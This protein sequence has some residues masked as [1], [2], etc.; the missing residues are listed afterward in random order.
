LNTFFFHLGRGTD[1]GLA[2][3]QRCF[4]LL[5][6]KRQGN[7]MNL[8]IE[9]NVNLTC[10]ESAAA[11]RLSAGSS[12]RQSTFGFV[13]L[14]MLVVLLLV[15]RQ[16]QFLQ[17]LPI[18]VRTSMAV[19]DESV[20]V[21]AATAIV[22]GCMWCCGSTKKHIVSMEGGNTRIGAPTIRLVPRADGF[23]MVPLYFCSNSTHNEADA[24]LTWHLLP[25][26]DPRSGFF[27]NAQIKYARLCGQCGHAD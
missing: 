13:L 4:F 27:S 17:G 21:V 7:H 3:P 2:V 9:L 5:C 11:C 22:V 8:M 6:L 12:C 26:S 1:I 16:R 19:L 20:V 25:F 14:V 24:L 15:T 18:E 23:F 10:T